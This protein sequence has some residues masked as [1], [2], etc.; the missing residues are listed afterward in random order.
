MIYFDFTA[1]KLKKLPLQGGV[2]LRE[3][4]QAPTPGGVAVSP[5]DKVVAFADDDSEHHKV[6]LGLFDPGSGATLKMMDFQRPINNRSPLQ[7]TRDGKAIVYATST[8][9]VDN[10]WL[11]PLDGSPG[12]Q[13]TNFT[14]EHIS[15]FQ[16]SLDGN[17]LAVLRGCTSNLTWS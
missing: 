17:K 8:D 4:Q 6:R 1:Q 15:N 10:L 14:S 11:Q 5:D 13:L 16:W 3:Y 12:K 9:D 2:P 7:F